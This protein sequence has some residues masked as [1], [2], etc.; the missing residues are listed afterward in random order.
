MRGEEAEAERPDSLGCAGCPGQAPRP[1]DGGAARG[2]STT[3]LERVDRKVRRRNR[4]Y[5]EPPADDPVNFRYAV[6]MTTGGIGDNI[7]GTCT[8]P[9]LMR[10]Y[11]GRVFYDPDAYTEPWVRALFDLPLTNV[12]MNKTFYPHGSYSLEMATRSERSRVDF[13]TGRCRN[14]AP[15]LPPVNELGRCLMPGAVVLCPMTQ[16]SNRTWYHWEELELMLLRRGVRTVVVAKAMPTTACFQGET[17][18]GYRPDEVVALLAGASCVVAADTG[19]A[20]VA[21]AVKVRTVILCG[22]TNGERI[23]DR[24]VYPTAEVV[25]GKP[26]GS[27]ACAGCYWHGTIS[28]ACRWFCASLNSVTPEE[29]C[30][31]VLR[32]QR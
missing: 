32:V 13:Y 12:R 1:R 7:L 17:Y 4:R 28:S 2:V 14:V 10:L 21:C 23:F 16:F 5:G 6:K 3:S 22:P 9:G 18:V 26:V 8:M 24:R 19:L 29:V 15:E 11:P 20:H 30:E 25:N 31:R 27:V